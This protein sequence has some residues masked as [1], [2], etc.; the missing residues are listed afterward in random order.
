MSEKTK[1]VII[2]DE[3]EICNL[4]KE[5]LERT[6]RYEVAISTHSR[7]GV[8]FIKLNNPALVLL[9]QRMPEMSGLQVAQAVLDDAATK[10]ITIVFLS[11][12]A[13]PMAFMAS[14]VETDGVPVKPDHA[15]GQYFIQKPISPQELVKRL[16]AIL[17]GTK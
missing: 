6:G 14:M 17:A 2:D 10:N 11:A 3:I 1:V 9:D 5:I 15:G 13:T 12:V 7:E 8:D 16:D 4:V